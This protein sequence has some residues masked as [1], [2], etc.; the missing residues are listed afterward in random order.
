MVA[1]SS[2]FGSL[3][4]L[5]LQNVLP[6]LARQI[7]RLD[8]PEKLEVLTIYNSYGQD[9]ELSSD[10]GQ[11]IGA[12]KSLR[13]LEIH[14]FLNEPLV[15]A[16]A[17]NNTELSLEALIV[18]DYVDSRTLEDIE[19]F[20]EALAFQHG[21]RELSINADLFEVPE[22]PVNPA[23]LLRSLQKLTELRTLDIQGVSQEFSQDQVLTLVSCLPHLERLTISGTGFND[24][25]WNS[26]CFSN[27]RYLK[28]AARNCF[29]AQGILD[30]ICGL[31]PQNRGLHLE[32]GYTLTE[33]N[34]TEEDQVTLREELSRRLDGSFVIW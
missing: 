20:H 11:W 30:F 14:V 27:L 34:I 12:C 18:P 28:I 16:N 8:P 10:V 5:K 7:S 6:A 22:R 32:L 21:M 24:S 23:T 13:R 26:L 29:T 17:L 9:D 25:V 4:E 33:S 19:A 2:H 3:V 15:L 1:L 31:G